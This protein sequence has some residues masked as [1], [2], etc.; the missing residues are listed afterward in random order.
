[1]KNGA[2][3]VSKTVYVLFISAFELPM[4]NLF[5]FVS[6][7]TCIVEQVN[8]KFNLK[9]YIEVSASVAG[10][11][12]RKGEVSMLVT[13][14]ILNQV[15]NMIPSGITTTY[16]VPFAC[17]RDLFTCKNTASSAVSSLVLD[18]GL[19]TLNTGIPYSIPVLQ[20]TMFP[21]RL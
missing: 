17:Y 1:M 8:A 19:C 7:V 11:P 18:R 12:L 4:P 2:N 13:E 9:S 20:L 15:P 21:Y 16:A 10:I 14:R 5:V 3:V 6:F